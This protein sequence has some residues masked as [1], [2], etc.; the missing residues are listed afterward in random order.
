MAILIRA[1]KLVIKNGNKPAF[2]AD[3]P[4][5]ELPD[6]TSHTGSPGVAP[7]IALTIFDADWTGGNLSWCDKTWT[8]AEIQAGA[9]KCV[10]PTLY[11][12]GPYV[13]TQW[14]HAWVHAALFGIYLARQVTYVG[15]T[16]I[17]GAANDAGITVDYP[18]PTMGPPFHN[19]KDG[20]F[21][22]YNSIS[23][24]QTVSLGPYT[25]QLN[26]ILTA[27]GRPLSNDYQLTDDFFGTYSAGGVQYTWV[28]GNDWV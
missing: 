5:S 15:G 19:A 17:Y 23:V 26:K 9:T 4:C 22:T 14:R 24:T 16:F 21:W 25:Y 7:S 3:D 1:G 28:R 27:P 13:T 8:P 20:R 18:T 10:C 11:E 2:P 12:K 6:C